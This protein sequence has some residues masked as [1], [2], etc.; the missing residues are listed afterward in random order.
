MNTRYDEL[1]TK[2]IGWAFILGPLLLVIG[3]LI[4]A[5]D[6][7]RNPNDLDSYV[8]GMFGYYGF[9]FFIPIWVSL[10]GVVGRRY[11]RYG[12]VLTVH[13]MMSAAAA[14]TPMAA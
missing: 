2:A 4:F 8:E 5:F 14:N 7:G 1:K 13:G 6:I 3:A 9:I 11:P 10:A 12:I